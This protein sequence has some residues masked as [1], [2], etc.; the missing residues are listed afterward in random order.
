MKNRIIRYILSL[1]FITVF[2]CTDEFESTNSNPNYPESA[3]I[4]NV[5]GYTIETLAEQFGTTEMEYPAAFVGYVT[6][7]TYT[8]VI[9]Y[10][11]EPGE[12]V[13][14]GALTTIFTNINYV[15]DGC[16]EEGNDNLK[17]AALII[18]TYAMQ[19]IVDIYGKIP[20][21]DAGKAEEG[22]TDPAYDDEE[23]IYDD[24]LNTLEEANSLF[25]NGQGG[26][27]GNG[28]L[29]YGGE[30]SQWQKFGNSLRLRIAIRISEVNETKAKTVIN[31]I[32]SDPTTY[33]IFE[34]N[35]DNALLAFP[36]DDWI[37]P[38]TSRHS[39]I[40]DDYIAEP[41]VDTLLTLNDPRI[42]FYAEPLEDGSYLGLEV[43]TDA[44]S[45]YSR[46][47]DLFVNNPTG[48]VYFLKYAEVEFIKAEAFTRSFTA[49]DAQEAY[50]SGITASCSE[51]DISESTI[52]TY[53]SQ[54]KVRWNNNLDQ[55]YIQKWIALFRQSWEA[56]AEMRRTDVPLLPPASNSG[57]SGHNRVPFRFPYPD[58]EDK[59]NGSNIPSSVT[60]EDY[61]WGYQIW[62]DTRSGVQ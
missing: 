49:G 12:G 3:P 54:E 17:A 20:Y 52:D 57:Y 13:W 18:K 21:F 58:S 40:G 24:L 15:L 26:L 39:S 7:G 4:T 50:Q 59:L 42:E 60:E 6:K 30:I 38:W 34:S 47:N 44:D 46:V 11:A 56:W 43:G 48:S 10:T 32:L 5:F 36:G 9:N 62:W 35:A 1:I 28:D 31:Q 23:A 45:D 41:I 55:I 33:P 8:D 53:L 14:S 27:L 51:Y 37:E 29:L 25:A 16:E 19:M 61:F 22:I 2:S